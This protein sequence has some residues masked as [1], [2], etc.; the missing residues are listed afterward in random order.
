MSVNQETILQIVKD[1]YDLVFADVMIGYMFEGKDKQNLIQRE[2]EL[3]SVFFELPGKY[4]GRSLLEAH[5][6]LRIQG[7]QFDRRM[8]LLRKAMEKNNL[9]SDIMEKWLEHNEMARMIVT[10]D[11]K[12]Q[13]TP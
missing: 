1:F 8:V 11:K 13:C 2:F 4:Q 9:A 3:T 10:A 7:G 12:G 6:L 5:R